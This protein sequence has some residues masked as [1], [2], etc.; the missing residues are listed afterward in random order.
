MAYKQKKQK[1]IIN[2]GVRGK[3]WT[4]NIC[5]YALPDET[6]R[7]GPLEPSV[8]TGEILLLPLL[9][10]GRGGGA[11][12]EGEGVH[13]ALFTLRTY[14]DPL[15]LEYSQERLEFQFLGKSAVLLLRFRSD[16]VDM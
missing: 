2:S 7:H 4:V 13:P 15:P 10:A 16:L 14:W 1:N 11:E 5:F 6:V 9:H 3:R 12:G 8:E